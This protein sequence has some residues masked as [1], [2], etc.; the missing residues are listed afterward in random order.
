M[1]H[2]CFDIDNV[3]AQTDEVMRRVIE[4]YTNGRVRLAYEDI[5]TFNY[6]E[7]LDRFGNGISKEEWNRV[8][9]V[10]SESRYLWL[11]QPFP[12]SVE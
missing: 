6:Y 12:G 11:I 8:H 4:D 1:V 3:I 10:F 2:F 7:C 9:E 5:K